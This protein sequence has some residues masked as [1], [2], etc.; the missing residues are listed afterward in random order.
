MVVVVVC[1]YEK[2]GV[3]TSGY[4]LRHA[5][6]QKHRTSGTT[7]PR[8]K[9]E[10]SLVNLCSFT[11]VCNPK[12]DDRSAIYMRLSRVSLPFSAADTQHPEVTRTPPQSVFYSAGPILHH[13]MEYLFEPKE[14]R[15]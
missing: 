15:L 1:C 5:L 8:Q 7:T 9:R 11:D 14:S 12:S 13:G 2:G 6:Q 10:G 4:Q 3:C